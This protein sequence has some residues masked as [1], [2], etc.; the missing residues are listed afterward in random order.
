MGKAFQKKLTNSWPYFLLLLVATLLYSFGLDKVPVHL[1]QDELEFSLN[2]YSISKTLKD[3]SGNFL[4]FY[5]WHLGSFWA[6]P[7]TTYLASLFLKFLP[8]EEA[9]I[10]L[11]SVFVGIS[12][13]GLLMILAKN[14]FK[15]KRLTLLSGVLAT[16]TPVLFM[17]SRLL[18]DNLYPVPFVVL[19]LL[20]LKKFIDKRKLL[21]LFA[22]GLS[23]GIGF[24][25]YHAAKILMPIYFLA[26]LIFLFW[27]KKDKIKAL[28]IFIV[29]F[30]TPILLAVPW[31]VKYP[32]SFIAN[33]IGYI[34]GLDGSV[35][36][37]SGFW[38]VINSDRLGQFASSYI[39][40]FGP[41]ILFISG[42]RSLIHSTHMS[43][44]FVF[45]VIFLL[46]FGII[47][48][49]FKTK[50]KF[51]R[52]IL[53][54][55]ISY[56]VAASL[57]N[58]P[59]RISRGL[60]VIPFVILL[61]VW[62]IKYLLSFKEKGIRVFVYLILLVSII[63]FFAFLIG[64]FGSYRKE[65]Y[66]WFNNDIGGAVE[67][68]IQSTKTRK[69]DNV[70][71]D[72][73][74]YFIERYVKFYSIKNSSDII[75]KTSYFDPQTQDFSSF[76]ENS[77]VIIPAHEIGEAPDKIGKF[78]KIEKISEPDGSE[79]FFLYYRDR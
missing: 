72:R 78:V 7:I 10:R 50:D 16:I 56:P 70:Y 27:E 51:A 77:L 23:L 4:P 46:V 54:G 48:V 11:P 22:S 55:F 32:D 8:L 43:G 52:L 33:Q 21:F 40:Y 6:T 38:G 67:R 59:S 39:N 49:L 9:M 65:S 25:S 69:V 24:H 13:I 68:A 19:W 47:Y 42:D 41:K 30:A 64:Y 44:A 18:L 28:G 2:A 76:P 20:F 26:S 63:Q 45:P 66:W 14:I 34:S 75:S 12:T 3:Q 74:I 5:I 57:V 36:A 17:H 31:F 62:G 15:D 71:L 73:N 61:S 37:Q 53:F 60:V 79:S 58:D 35:S 1:N 29:G